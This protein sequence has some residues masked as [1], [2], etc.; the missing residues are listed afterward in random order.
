MFNLGIVSSSQHKPSGGVPVEYIGFSATVGA[1]GT[2]PT[3]NAGDLILCF[4]ASGHGNSI[5]TPTGYTLIKSSTVGGTWKLST[6]LSYKI[7][8][9]TPVNNT[10]DFAGTVCYAVFRNA[11]TTVQWLL[12]QSTVSTATSPAITP[13]VDNGMFLIFQAQH[14]DRGNPI[15]PATGM[16]TIWN[17][18]GS[19]GSNRGDNDGMRDTTLTT[20]GLLI[21][22]KTTSQLSSTR[23]FMC[24]SIV[25]NPT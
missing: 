6:V 13:T 5:V 4:S 19:S 1:S 25:V 24:Y 12:N 2:E 16:T 15:N 23:I 22:S 20:N 11:S 17:I 18:A 3:H 7:G 8:T 10:M 14:K 21:P 9:G